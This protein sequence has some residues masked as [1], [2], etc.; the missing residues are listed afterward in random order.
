M[1]CW[2]AE[3]DLIGKLMQS[4]GAAACVCESVSVCLPLWIYLRGAV[5]VSHS[6]RHFK[7]ERPPPPSLSLTPTPISFPLPLLSTHPILHHWCKELVLY[8]CCLP[9]SFPA[10]A[11]SSTWRSTELQP[12]GAVHLHLRAPCVCVCV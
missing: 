1:A 4:V 6:C 12:S 10:P 5:T 7:S 11:S 2:E 8:Y 3:E 9:P